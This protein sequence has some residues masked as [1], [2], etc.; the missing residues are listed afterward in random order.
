MS[1]LVGIPIFGQK[2]RGSFRKGVRV[3][4]EKGK[5]KRGREKGKGKGKRERKWQVNARTFVKT[6]LQQT[7][8]Q[9]LPPLLGTFLTGNLNFKQF[10]SISV[11]K[12]LGSRLSG[13][14][15]VR[16][17]VTDEQ[18]MKEHLQF[19]KCPKG[20]LGLRGA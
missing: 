14:D 19:P 9:P 17:L 12:A 4:M 8:L 10:S 16:I 6:T 11:E 20:G 1:L 2:L 3:P 15:E 5:G 7:T 13:E 18:S